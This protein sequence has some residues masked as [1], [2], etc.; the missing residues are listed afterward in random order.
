MLEEWSRDHR[1][2]ID[3][4]IYLTDEVI[5][6]ITKVN[7][8]PNKI[9]ATSEPSDKIISNL[10]LLPRRPDQIQKMMDKDRIAR[11]TEGKNS[12]SELEKYHKSDVRAPPTTYERLKKISQQLKGCS[13]CCLGT[14][15]GW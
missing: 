8:N 14:S 7:P 12:D 4:G 9:V 5:K 3:K 2:E 13:R 10:I 15:V 1:R 11:E 6:C